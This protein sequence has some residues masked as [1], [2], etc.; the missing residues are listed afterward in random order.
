MTNRE[1][2]MSK[3]TKAAIPAGHYYVDIARYMQECAKVTAAQMGLLS[4]LIRL[5]YMRSKSLPAKVK[6]RIILTDY[7]EADLDFVLNQYFPNGELKA[8]L[9]HEKT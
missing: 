8:E 6:D 2:A 9:I 4:W 1:E 7:T 5:Y 3:A